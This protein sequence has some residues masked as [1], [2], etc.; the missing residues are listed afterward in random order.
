MTKTKEIQKKEETLPQKDVDVYENYVVPSVDIYE[1]ENDYV[2]VSDMPG[3]AKERLDIKLDKQNLIITGNVV[4]PKT[5]DNDLLIN[6][7]CPASFHRHF[8]IADDVDRDN[9]DAKL[10]NGVLKLTMPKKEDYKPR[11]IQ[12]N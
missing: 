7:C 5:D 11:T 6:E 3:V 2:I 8:S 9:I 12:I 10:E 1:T 4:K